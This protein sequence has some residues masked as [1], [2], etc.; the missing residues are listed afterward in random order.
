MCESLNSFDQ[1]LYKQHTGAELGTR[2]GPTLAN[3]FL[4]YYEKIWIQ[5]CTFEF[6][7]AIYKKYDDNASLLFR[8]EHQIKKF[9]NY[10]NL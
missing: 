4:C 2:L 9:R 1:K 7:T 3:V 10:L 5:K 6:K 8:L